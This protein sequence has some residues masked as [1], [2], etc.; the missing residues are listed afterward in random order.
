MSAR[1]HI[2]I[3]GTGR[4]GTTF[5]V[6]L[7]KELGLDTG[8]GDYFENCCAGLEHDLRE[9]NA[10]FIVKSPFLCNQLDNIIT[11]F[12]VSI[13]HLIIPVRDLFSAAQSRRDVQMRALQNNPIMRDVP[14]GLWGTD[15]PAKQEFELTKNF[16]NLI[17]VASQHEIPITFLNFP[18]IV[19][20]PK[21]LRDKL[22]P[23]FGRYKL[24]R[25]RFYSAFNKISKP[26][27][28]HKYIVE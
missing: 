5:L 20:D 6:Q 28:V 1:S 24:R 9:E 15:D 19:N 23:I 12:D 4:A 14:G 25:Q 21:Y 3:S 2:L 10:P 17:Q 18:R 7:L 26:S 11:N 16:Y 22:I 8:E 27:L 13:K